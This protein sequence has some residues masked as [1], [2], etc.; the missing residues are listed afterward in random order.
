MKATKTCVAAQR[1]QYDYLNDDI[2][3]DGRID[4]SLSNKVPQGLRAAIGAGKKILVLINP[5]YGEAANSLGNEGKTDIARTNIGTIMNNADYGYAARELF[6]QFLVRIAKEIPTS[7]VAIFSTLKYVNAPNFE[8]F[9]ENWNAK[10]LGGF[11]VHSKAFDG[12][13]GN[14][15][16]GLLVWK[17]DQNSKKI[18]ITVVSTE[19]LDKKANAIGEK[20]FFNL[21]KSIFLSGWMA[22]LKTDTTAIPL[23]NAITPQT[24]HAKVTSW[25]EDAIGYM[26]SNSNDLQHSGTLTALFSSVCSQGNGYHVTAENLWQVAVVF[27]VR[28]LVKHMV[29]ASSIV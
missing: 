10:Y 16:I 19:V 4:Y 21:P 17:T 28:L 5:P 25:R 8:K 20:S 9:R 18:P 3:D 12:L 6:V 23:K 22:R 26:L 1:F 7:T 11:V 24:G 14:F 29:L 13:T 2:T 15:P 27:A